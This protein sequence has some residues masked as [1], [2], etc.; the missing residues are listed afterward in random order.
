VQ[1]AIE[2]ASATK[3]AA[4]DEGGERLSGR[5]PRACHSQRY[6]F[7]TLG[8]RLSDEDPLILLEDHDAGHIEAGM[9]HSVEACTG[10]DGEAEG[11]LELEEHV[12]V[13]ESGVRCQPRTARRAPVRHLTG[14]LRC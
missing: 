10:I 5:L 1:L 8:S 4:F 11:R 2:E 7:I 12:L 6:P 14:S 3:R 13:T 9:L